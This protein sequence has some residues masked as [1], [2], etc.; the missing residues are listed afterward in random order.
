MYTITELLSSSLF[1]IV[2]T[3]YLAG[4]LRRD[5][6]A[7]IRLIWYF[8]SLG[9]VVTI[10]VLFWSISYY[11]EIIEE[12]R[13]YE[14]AGSPKIEKFKMGETTRQV[15]RLHDMASNIVGEAKLVGAIVTLLII[16]QVLS[17]VF[18]GM[19]GCASKPLL[20]GAGFS[21]MAWS[22][23]KFFAF[24]GGVTLCTGVVAQICEI[25]IDW[26]QLYLPLTFASVWEAHMILSLYRKKDYY[27]K[28]IKDHCPTRLWQAFEHAHA[29]ATRNERAPIH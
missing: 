7:D 14:L 13:N 17:Y 5:H 25:F 10:L 18:S 19:F 1:F 9:L 23:V 4:G 26:K 15:L 8:F 11:P 22:A 12:I 29:W 6:S 20:V 21:F 3:I 24:L 16:P 2:Y 28:W 27:I